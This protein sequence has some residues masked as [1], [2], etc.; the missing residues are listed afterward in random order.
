MP[1]RAGT[2]VVLLWSLCLALDFFLAR[3]IVPNS[4]T[5]QLYNELPSIDAGNIL[6]RHW[7]LTA[8]NFTLTDLPFYVLLRWLI[9]DRPQLAFLVPW[10]IFSLFLTACLLLVHDGG[11]RGFRGNAGRFAILYLVGLPF[12]AHLE[13]FLSAAIHTGTIS[14]CL[15]ALLIVRPILQRRRASRLR[16]LAFAGLLLAAA[17]SDPF[18]DVIF[19]GPFLLLLV[20]RGCAARALRRDEA[21]VA[22]CLVAAAL[23]GIALVHAVARLGGFTTASNFSTDFIGSVGELR[24]N[25]TAIRGAIEVLF[26]TRGT[27][28]H[29]VVGYRAIALTRILPT[30]CV[31]ALCLRTLWRLPKAPDAG[32]AQCLAF[33]AA[34]LLLLDCI[35]GNFTRAVSNGVGFPNA[36]IRYVLPAFVFGS[37]AAAIEFQTICAA[38]GQ[39]TLRRC[40]LAIGLLTGIFI[41]GA[42]QV[43]VRTARLPSGFARAPQSEVAAWL[44]AHRFSYGV[45][46][47]WTTQMVQAITRGRVLADPLMSDGRRIVPL[48]WISDVSRFDRHR[49]PQF[50]VYRLQNKFGITPALVQASFGTKL[51]AYRLGDYVIV[52]LAA[53]GVPPP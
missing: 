4:D 25:L 35:S 14:F 7:V 28:L 16:L 18:A 40:G 37:I 53:P 44:V 12:G 11:H 22:L 34:C 36:A 6:L 17:A 49:P 31:V 3:S 19:I 38:M 21:L 26:S 51:Q 41:L 32:V 27:L 13:M 30:L 8:D 52:Q 15:Y 23:G 1:A 46:D 43:A 50:V 47:Y 48:R 5:M 2:W 9:G 24:S 33:S 39:R 29:Q 10:L 20:L 45:G 42:V